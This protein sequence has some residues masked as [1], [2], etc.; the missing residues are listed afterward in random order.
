MPLRS[1]ALVLSAL[2]AIT[3]APAC[4]R[5]PA[6]QPPLPPE[7][8]PEVPDVTEWFLGERV[9]G[10]KT[11][12]RGIALGLLTIEA[13]PDS[14]NAKTSTHATPPAIPTSQPTAEQ[15]A[16]GT[17]RP[18]SCAPGLVSFLPEPGRPN[19]WLGVDDSGQLLRYFA[20]RWSPVRSKVPLPRLVALLGFDG[21]SL[22]VVAS[23]HHGEQL[24]LL[25]FSGKVVTNHQIVDPASLGDRQAVL[26]RYR[27]GRCLE[28]FKSC[29]RITETDDGIVVSREPLPNEYYV[30][31][32]TLGEDGVNDVRYA[33]AKGTKID[34]L[35]TRACVATTEPST[36][37]EARP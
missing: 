7:A 8:T 26:Q 3:L 10:P 14:K 1:T 29:L 2:A 23:H 6:P 21:P 28:G 37:P 9:R 36:E 25:T 27:G 11:S 12:N 32:A 13:T 20:E 17:L 19:M 4:Y 31:I 30:T 33:D 24:A 22:L 34:V 18:G 15:K 16:E 35:T 5:D